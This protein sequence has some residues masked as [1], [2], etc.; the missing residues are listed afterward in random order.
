VELFKLSRSEYSDF[1]RAAE[2]DGLRQ[3]SKDIIQGDRHS[4]APLFQLSKDHAALME[5]GVGIIMAS[6]DA[7]N[8]PF[9]GRAIG[10]RVS[11]DSGQVKIFFSRRKYPSLL[12]AIRRTGAIAASFSEPTSHKSLQIKAMGA[13]LAAIPGVGRVQMFRN[14]RVTFRKATV[15]IMAI[16]VLLPIS[17]LAPALG[18]V[19][20]PVLYWPILGLTLLAY[21]LLTQMVKVLLVRR[22]WI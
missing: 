21:L 15:T 7:Q 5:S 22:H 14:G 11:L 16:G 18:F 6:R 12:D 13:E 9:L 2:A 1:R 8:R 17:P 3:T 20:L 19:A 10:C 4:E